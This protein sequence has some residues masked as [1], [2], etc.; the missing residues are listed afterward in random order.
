VTARLVLL[1]TT[2]R[3]AAGLLSWAAWQALREADTVLVADQ[4]HPLL[5]ALASADI[6]W[7]VV[8]A[9]AAEPAATTRARTL[10][11][12][13]TTG[14]ALWVGSPDGDPGLVE[15]L[16]SLLAGQASGTGAVLP[17]VELL[18]GSWDVPGARLLDA[19]AVMDRLRS[20]GGCPWDARQTH[21]SL[22]EY[23]VEETYETLEAI[24]TGDDAGLREELGDVLLQVLFHSRI[25]QERENDPWSVDDVAAGIVDKLVARH[26]HV[27]A[28]VDAETAEQVEANWHALKAVEKGRASVTDGIPA[29]L[30]ALVLAGKL[31]SRADR[32]GVA[33][34]AP[35]APVRF[36]DDHELGGLLLA[37]VAAAREQGLDAESALRGAVRQHR[38][39]VRAAE[40]LP[41]A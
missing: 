12:A 26:P 13:S 20:P 21:A 33:V 24:E 38:A 27:F 4:D 2:H 29:A 22:V 32:A 19:V 31:L 17:E 5:P 1:A 3:V 14:T 16:S 15:Q 37:I 9:E 30:P 18:A 6:A 25:A 36:T 7:T 40:G 41:P 10:L 11:G 8:P 28:D 35:A 39:A 23:L 34:A